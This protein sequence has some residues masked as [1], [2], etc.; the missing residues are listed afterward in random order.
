[1]N[2]S[3]MVGKSERKKEK[4]L[5]SGQVKEAILV[6]TIVF[7]SVIGLTVLAGV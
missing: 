5:Y 1:M 4:N 3:Q 7:F 6:S 2:I